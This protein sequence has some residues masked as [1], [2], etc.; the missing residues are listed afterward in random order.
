MISTFRQFLP[1]ITYTHYGR[2]S[3]IIFQASAQ[4]TI[5]GGA[6]E[7]ARKNLATRKKHDRT[8]EV[9]D[10]K[11]DTTGCEAKHKRSTISVHI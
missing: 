3:L 9:Y 8:S 10:R 7:R 2:S 1:N 11:Y 6:Y 5:S 4:T